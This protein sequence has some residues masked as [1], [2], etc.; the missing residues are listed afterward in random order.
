LEEGGGSEEMRKGV[1]V[2]ALPLSLAVIAIALIAVSSAGSQPPLKYNIDGN[3]SDWG[4]NLTGNWSLNETWV[5]NEGIEFVVEDNNDPHHVRYAAGVHI[6]GVGSHYEYYYER[7]VNCSG[8]PMVE[9][10]GG[11]PFDIEAKYFD[12]DDNYIYVAIVTSMAPSNW[13][14]Y[15]FQPGDFAMN[16]DGDESTGEYG[17]EYGVK[18]FYDDLTP[19]IEQWNISYLPNWAEPTACPENAPGKM[20]GLLP[21]GKWV[22]KAFGAYVQCTSCNLGESC[23]FYG[24]SYTGCDHG[25]PNYVVEMAIPKSAVNMTGKNLTEPPLPKALWT[26]DTCGNDKIENPIPEFLTVVIPAAALICFVFFIHRRRWGG[27]K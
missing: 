10:I 20:V 21:G 1:K 12:E 13:P 15:D 19:E 6:K 24:N 9:P 16:L 23:T 26:C 27:G 7:M 3:L 2:I 18:I 5:P 4:V 14:G 25:V 17:Y 8:S 11:E 22:G